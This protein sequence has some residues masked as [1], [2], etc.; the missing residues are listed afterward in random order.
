YARRPH[1]VG[2]AGFLSDEPA[3]S[4][5][6]SI[7]EMPFLNSVTLLPNDR[8]AL[9]RRLPKIKRQMKARMII[10]HGP[11]LG[12]KK[13]KGITDNL[14]TSLQRQFPELCSRIAARRQRSLA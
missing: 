9:G 14:L 12:R 6:S 11:T 4:M 7:P 5:S 3:W 10:S 8:I 2:G 13:A 1:G